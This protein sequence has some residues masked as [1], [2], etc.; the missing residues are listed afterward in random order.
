MLEAVALGCYAVAPDTLAYPEYLPADGLFA[1]AGLDFPTQARSAALCI[2]RHA[3]V[4]LH[5]PTPVLNHQD[6][7]ARVSASA[8]RS[9]W[10]HTFQALV[11]S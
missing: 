8:L 1:A 11:K 10:Q 7:A 2:Q 6:Y 4:L 3:Q 9:S 5:S